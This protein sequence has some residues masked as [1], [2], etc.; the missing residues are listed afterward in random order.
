MLSH[1]AAAYLLRLVRGRPPEPA[2]TVPHART[3]R[4][5]GVEVHRTRHLHP[6]DHS[7]LDGIPLSTVP[8]TL[9]DLAATLPSDELGR[10]CHE[11]QVLHRVTPEAVEVVIARTGRRHGTTALLRLLRGDDHVTLSPLERAFLTLLRDHGLPLPE[12]NRPAGADRVDCRW[13]DRRLVVEL[14]GYRFHATRQAWEEDLRRERRARARG[15]E[16][17]RFTWGDVVDRPA[18]TLAE[19]RTLLG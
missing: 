5:P 14:D 7:V 6:L 10:A 19:L 9:V 17:R 16:H 12:T 8:R 11:A 2:V 18:A 15:D 4:V 3:P 1:L 13:P